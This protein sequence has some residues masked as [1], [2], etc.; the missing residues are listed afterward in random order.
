MPTFRSLDVFPPSLDLRTILAARSAVLPQITGAGSLLT[1]LHAA[2]AVTS[3]LTG[4]SS[5]V[6]VTASL[7]KKLPSAKDPLLPLPDI[8]G[9]RMSK[10][11]SL[12]PGLCPGDSIAF[13]KTLVGRSAAASALDTF[14]KTLA[15]FN[16]PTPTKAFWLSAPSKSAL[17]GMAPAWAGATSVI[18]LGLT[19]VPRQ[20]F[21]FDP[22]D[23][24][25]ASLRGSVLAAMPRAKALPWGLPEDW[26]YPL[27]SINRLLDQLGAPIVWEARAALNSYLQ[28]DP[29]PM[30]EF[31][32]DRLRLRPATED[33][34]QALAFALL[35]REWENHVDLQDADAVRLALRAC[36]REGND[37]DSDH[38][39]MGH[40]VG[41][42]PVGID[43]RSPEPGPEDVAV[44][45]ATPWADRFDSQHVRYATK[46][47]KNNEQRVARVWAENSEL[48]W[49][50]APLL[51]DM[52]VD[53]GNR[54]RRKL[55]RAGDE[56]VRR[57]KAQILGES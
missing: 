29:G 38:Q 54:V 10:L 13:R 24:P 45:A 21:R 33:H 48:N 9:S 11:D 30:G 40:S 46:R 50:Q 6:N 4:L 42:L 32:H 18:G 37:L 15:G 22:A 19:P 28:G 51:V 5:T 26:L 23:G 16:G 27:R 36:A 25:M 3:N 39:V 14:S 44:S 49:H 47:L 17:F 35:L 1:S 7:M 55:L 31:L 20:L 57:T 34:A 8:M 56:I 52:D 41:H 2:R 43:L 12:L 53:M